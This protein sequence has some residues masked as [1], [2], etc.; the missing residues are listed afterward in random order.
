LSNTLSASCLLENGDKGIGHRRMTLHDSQATDLATMS[1]L[2]SQQ[3]A[4]SIAVF[5]PGNLLMHQVS[6]WAIHYP[7]HDFVFCFPRTAA[8]VRRV[9]RQSAIAIVDATDDPAQ[10]MAAIAQATDLL[11]RERV[12]VYTESIHEGLELFVRARGVLL[13]LGPMGNA[14]WDDQL[15]TMIQLAAR[16]HPCVVWARPCR[17]TISGLP[18]T[19]LRKR[20][21]QLLCGNRHSRFFPKGR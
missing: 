20:R 6:D 21:L 9:L 3:S 8:E 19:G 7:A 5:Y 4:V 12:A 17:E 10:A 15:T 13:L 2:I 1:N 16:R 18:S 11:E 14:P